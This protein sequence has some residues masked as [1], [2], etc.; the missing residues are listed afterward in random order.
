[1][2]KKIKDM[3]KYNQ[4]CLSP[5]QSRA[6]KIDRGIKEGLLQR[7]SVELSADWRLLGTGSVVKTAGV[8]FSPACRGQGSGSEPCPLCRR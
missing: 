7:L 1:M 5:E 4:G 8:G 2:L 6:G 3:F